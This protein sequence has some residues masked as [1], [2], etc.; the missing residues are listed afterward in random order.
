[1]KRSHY[2]IGKDNPFFG[3][4]HTEETKQKISKKNFIRGYAIC[5]SGYE[6]MCEN[7][8]WG[9]LRHRII[10]ENLL[11]RRLKPNEIVH[12]INGKRDD[13]RPENLML[14]ANRGDH[15]NL[16]KKRNQNR[17]CIMVFNQR[18]KKENGQWISSTR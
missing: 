16:H 1:M 4:K 3:K 5:S 12:H 10:M 14:F 7:R 8:G 18:I 9:R 6:R 2:N 11:G 17:N 15:L 13:N